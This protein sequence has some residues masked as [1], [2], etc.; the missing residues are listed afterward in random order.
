LTNS[1][2]L[3]SELLASSYLL[4][5]FVFTDLHSWVSSH[6]ALASS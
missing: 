3:H 5:Y 4:N 2:A 6:T 1:P